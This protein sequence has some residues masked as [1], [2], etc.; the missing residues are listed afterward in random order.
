MKGKRRKNGNKFIIVTERIEKYKKI[1]P[2]PK[3]KT[4]EKIESE[5]IITERKK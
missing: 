4:R 1:P 2:P 3:K 5:K